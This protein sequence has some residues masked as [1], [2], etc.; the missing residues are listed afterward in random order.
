MMNRRCL[1]YWFFVVALASSGIFSA[2]LCEAYDIRGPWVGSASGTIFG[3]KGSVNITHQRGEDIR[4]IVEGGN[5][6]GSA[7]FSITGT[8]RGNQIYGSKDGHT[9]QGYVFPNGTIRGR[10]R[11]VDGDSYEVFLHRPYPYWGMPYGSW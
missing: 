4:G 7:R 11:A 3:A 6:F 9:F 2:H 5:V 1:R 8:I 10:F